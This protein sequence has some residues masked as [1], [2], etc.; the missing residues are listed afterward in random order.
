MGSLTE[1]SPVEAIVLFEFHNQFPNGGSAA[2]KTLIET[3]DGGNG[4]QLGFRRLMGTVRRKIDL[5]SE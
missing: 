2:K 3:I 5:W 1:P 4:L